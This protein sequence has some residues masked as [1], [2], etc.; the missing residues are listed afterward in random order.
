MAA[1][2]YRGYPMRNRSIL[3]CCLSVN[4]GPASEDRRDHV[5]RLNLESVQAIRNRPAQLSEQL[6]PV[7]VRREDVCR[8]LTLAL[9]AVRASLFRDGSLPVMSTSG[10]RIL[11]RK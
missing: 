1:R 8:A 5:S 2:A 9:V 6:R 10:T 7:R 3:A 11:Q 4:S